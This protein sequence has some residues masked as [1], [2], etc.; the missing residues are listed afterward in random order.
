MDRFLIT[1]WFNRKGEII[2]LLN[3]SQNKTKIL[4]PKNWHSKN[5]N[6]S[7]WLHLSV[8]TSKVCDFVCLQ[9]SSCLSWI[10]IVNSVIQNSVKLTLALH[11]FYWTITDFTV[12]TWGDCQ[13]LKYCYHLF[14]SLVWS[15]TQCVLGVWKLIIHGRY[16]GWYLRSNM[17]LLCWLLFHCNCISDI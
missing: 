17:C 12:T 15:A 13:V 14:N 3:F 1:H 16:M 11:Q 4:T 9:S 5:K 8:L 10:I 2:C 6:P 7:G